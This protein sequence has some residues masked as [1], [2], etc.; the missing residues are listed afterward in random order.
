MRIVGVRQQHKLQDLDVV[1]SSPTPC[2][3]TVAGL[4]QLVEHQEK[5][6]SVI[7]TIFEVVKSGTAKTRPHGHCFPSKPESTLYFSF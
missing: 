4:A 2:A 3:N 5:T 7:R 6:D 1:G